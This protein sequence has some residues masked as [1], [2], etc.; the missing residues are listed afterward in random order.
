LMVLGSASVEEY[1]EAIHSFNERGERAK[2]TELAKRL[3]VAP[4]A[5]PRC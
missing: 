2:N 3:K 4:P 1:L 5:S